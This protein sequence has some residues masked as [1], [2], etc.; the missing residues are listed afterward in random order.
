M[1]V[2]SRSN[3]ET[4]SS[5]DHFKALLSKDLNRVSCLNFWAP[6]AEPCAAFNK[7]V[8]AAA[9]KFPSILFLKVSLH[10]LYSDNLRDAITEYQHTRSSYPLL[11]TP[12][13]ALLD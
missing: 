2:M 10:S 4:V 13:Y 11:D 9:D 7:E 3:L 1:G 12:A 5:P 8:E 6:W